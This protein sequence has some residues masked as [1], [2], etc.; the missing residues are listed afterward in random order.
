V[1]EIAN[2][3]SQTH[4]CPQVYAV[5]APDGVDLMVDAH[6]AVEYPA[7]VSDAQL[8]EHITSGIGTALAFF[9]HLDTFFPEAVAE[10]R[11]RLG[12]TDEGTPA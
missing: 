9:E 3:W 2:A 4:P 12:I 6:H 5:P 7:G 11:Q 10:A 1:L 8:A